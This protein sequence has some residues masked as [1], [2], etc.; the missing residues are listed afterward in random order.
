MSAAVLQFPG[1]RRVPTAEVINTSQLALL[2][3]NLRSASIAMQ[4][5]H[6]RL[7]LQLCDEFGYG[8]D[9]LSFDQPSLLER[10]F[11]AVTRRLL[12]LQATGLGLGWKLA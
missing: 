5:D 9:I 12:E 2:R 3:H 7:L 6:Q 10:D 4:V 11:E 8:A 1:G